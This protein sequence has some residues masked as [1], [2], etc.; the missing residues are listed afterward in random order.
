MTGVVLKLL[1][2]ASELN[3]TA[4]QAFS[5]SAPRGDP[6]GPQRRGFARQ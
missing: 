3:A 1:A 2:D 6:D 4:R 5:R